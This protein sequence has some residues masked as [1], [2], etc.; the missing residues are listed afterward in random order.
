V[1]T[2]SKSTAHFTPA[3]TEDDLQLLIHSGGFRAL[4]DEARQAYDVVIID[5]PPVTTSPDSALIA[6]FADTRLFLVRWGRTSWDEMTAAVGFLRLC[7][8]G[9]DGIVIIGADSDSASYGQLA[10]HETVPADARVI[11]P[12]LYRSLSNVD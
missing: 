1:Q 6:K 11:G 2:D 3:P 9:L 10:S 8:V 7:R 5:T 12:A 4:I